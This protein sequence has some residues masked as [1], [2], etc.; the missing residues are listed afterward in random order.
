MG[1]VGHS[2]RRN[3]HEPESQLLCSAVLAYIVL[4]IVL[5]TAAVLVMAGSDSDI[6]DIEWLDNVVGL[7]PVMSIEDTQNKNMID[8]MNGWVGTA[9]Q[10]CPRTPENIDVVEIPGGPKVLETPQK[11][12]KKKRCLEE[13]L[14]RDA[15]VGFAWK[16]N[17]L[18]Q[19]TPLFKPKP[20]PEDLDLDSLPAAANGPVPSPNRANMV[21]SSFF[22]VWRMQSESAP[23]PKRTRSSEYIS[24]VVHDYCGQ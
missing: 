6:L 13:G 14:E 24:T 22:G 1:Y 11:V 4:V 23:A 8:W 2:V 5:V 16:G 3:Q 21:Y 19:V 15:V 17:T 20:S 18:V 9:D 10:N 7:A 12:S